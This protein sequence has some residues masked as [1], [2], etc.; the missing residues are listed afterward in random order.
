MIKSRVRLIGWANR[1]ERAMGLR[2]AGG[3]SKRVGWT[4]KP[5]V[6]YFYKSEKLICI[7]GLPQ[8]GEF[9]GKVKIA[10]IALS[11]ERPLANLH[12]ETNDQ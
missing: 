9:P 12:N 6:F 5:I 1:F 2:E 3:G 4:S 8:G 11:A 10:V 7:I